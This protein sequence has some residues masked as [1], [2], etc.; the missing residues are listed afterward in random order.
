MLTR[1]GG[2]ELIDVLDEELAWSSDDDEDFAIEFDDFLTTD[3]VDDI[4]DY[5][6]EVDELTQLE[7]DQCEIEEEYYEAS[8]LVGMF[9]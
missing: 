1:G 5:L 2:A 4:L 9:R 3:D 8:D 6:E 7:A